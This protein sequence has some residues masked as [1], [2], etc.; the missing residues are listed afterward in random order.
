M[1]LGEVTLCGWS[2]IFMGNGQQIL[3]DEQVPMLTLQ[4]STY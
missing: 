1:T 2:D 3:D 4:F